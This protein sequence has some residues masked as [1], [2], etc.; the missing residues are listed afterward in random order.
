MAGVPSV[1]R[2][3]L[4]NVGPKP[5]ATELSMMFDYEFNSN[6]NKGRDEE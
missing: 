1:I 2:V 5:L 3:G 4:E 6:L